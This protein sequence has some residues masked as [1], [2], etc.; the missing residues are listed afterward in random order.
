MGR[1]I[2]DK[3]RA[4]LE[5]PRSWVWLV[6]LSALLALPTLLIGFYVDDWLFLSVLEG[7]LPLPG[8]RFDLYH[9]AS[10]SPDQVR[11]HV[12]RGALPWWTDNGLT[13]H[14]FRPLASSL[15]TLDHR[16]FGVWPVGYHAHTIAWYVGFVAAVGYFLRSVLPRSIA[17]LALLV[18]VLDGTHAETMGWIANRHMPMAAVPSLTALGFYLRRRSASSARYG[19]V[20]ALGLA[21]GLLAGETALGAACYFFAYEAL[22][23]AW[24]AQAKADLRARCLETLRVSWPVL[25]TLVVYLAGYKALGYGAKHSGGYLDPFA[26]PGGFLALLC[27]RFPGFLGDYLAGLP[28]ALSLVLPQ[29]LFVTVGIAAVLVTALL[30]RASLPLLALEERRTLAWLALGALLSLVPVAGGLPTSRLLSYAG[31][32]GAVVV[33]YLLRYGWQCVSL[34]A[35]RHWLLLRRA[36][37]ISVALV[38]LVLSPLTLLLNPQVMTQLGRQMEA[39]AMGVPFGVT[40]G[41]HVV[42]LSAADPMVGMYLGAIRAVREPGRFA[43]WN[44]LSMGK[45]TH[46]IARSGPN[47]L[48]ISTDAS[49]LKGPFERLFRR[50]DVPFRVGERVQLLGASV[51]VQAVDNGT[52]TR[53]E[54]ELDVL[55]DDPR[56]VLVAWRDHALVRVALPES[57]DAVVIPWTPGPLGIL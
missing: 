26:D 43:S 55:L 29:V 25:V 7:A 10:G 28:V 47:R 44:I 33:A 21:V 4:F 57:G 37:F 22:R 46:R 35:A 30:V 19:A 36:G 52:P 50:P 20:L 54:V 23:V 53:F 45:L 11:A 3:A 56:L 40:T 42:I 6:A 15:I 14:F 32:G 34:G 13:V 48:V 41:Q 5:R 24:P 9:F 2:V 51:T 16:L 27:L 18:F 31:I 1:S 17:A 38:H 8:S 39:L 49:F 12:A